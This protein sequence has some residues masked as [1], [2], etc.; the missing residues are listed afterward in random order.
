LLTVAL[1]K[2]D[3]LNLSNES[4]R[5]PSSSTTRLRSS[6]PIT[7]LSLSYLD[8]VDPLA[9]DPTSLLSLRSLHLNGHGTLLQPYL[10][11]LPQL[12]SLTLARDLDSQDLNT[13][14]AASTAVTSL[15]TTFNN[16]AYL[17]PASLLM[18]KQRI[19]TLELTWSELVKVAEELIK[20]IEG[21]EVMKKIIL[22]GLFVTGGSE[23]DLHVTELVGRVKP[24]CK[25]KGIELW[26]KNF[27][28]NNGK[29]DLDSLPVTY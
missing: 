17:D 16:I 29:V 22:D 4:L 26:R 9:L 14:L 13:L 25:K 5:G 3:K 11:L 15:S 20:I 7:Y 27:R 18:M 19:T 8:D 23:R 21:S 24:G 6:L 10:P 28:T 1:K 2:L 12:T